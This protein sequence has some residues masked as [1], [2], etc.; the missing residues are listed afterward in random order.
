MG[1]QARYLI[2]DSHE[3]DF[4]PTVDLPQRLALLSGRFGTR[5]QRVLPLT[6]VGEPTPNSFDPGP[7]LSF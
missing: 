5:F 1:P 7:H 6:T 2:D 4:A 3:A